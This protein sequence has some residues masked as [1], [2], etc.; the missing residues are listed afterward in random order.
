MVWSR[1]S[2]AAERPTGVA[3]ASLQAMGPGLTQLPESIRPITKVQRLLTAKAAMIEAGEALDWATGEA[4]AFGSLLMEGVPVRLSGQDAGRGT[5]SHRHSVIVDEATEATYLPLNHLRSDQTARYEVIDSNLSE[6]GVLGFEYGYSMTNPNSLVLWEGQFGD[7]SNG[8]QI[9][10]DQFIASGETK[11]QRMSGLVML[12]PHGM[13]G[14]GPEHSSAR[15]ER[16]LQLC[17]DGNMSV[18]YCTTPASYF[19]VLRRQMHRNF[20]RPLIV[21]TPKS[22]LRH[23][24]AVS[25]LKDM[26]EGTAFRPLLPDATIADPEAVRRVIFC[27][28]KVYYD[29][30]EA[31]EEKEKASLALVRLEQ[32]YPF[33]EEQVAAVCAEYVRATSFVWCQEEPENQGAWSF[34][35]PLFS[36]LFDAMG[37]GQRIVYVGRRAS[38]SPAVGYMSV[39]Q[40]EQKALVAEALR[41]EPVPSSEP[42]KSES[43]KGE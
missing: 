8:A 24:L 12:L 13:E 2:Q 22:L 3:I 23:K 7:F 1:D 11:W 43:K 33:P 34:V 15:L 10:I 5:F 37:Q 41:I 28:G 32:L 27:S 6:Y 26:D 21:M 14:Q 4:L 25:S 17:A 29:L 39:H 9:M 38:A 20:R 18:V 40:S 30:Y 16:Y 36:R 19:H 42:L 31:R 35:Q